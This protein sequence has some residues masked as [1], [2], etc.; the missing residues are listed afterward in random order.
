M[1]I[2]LRCAGESTAARALPPLNPPSLPSV[3]AAG[4]LEWAEGSLPRRLLDSL[5]GDLG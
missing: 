5:E 2:S 4:F 3:T 1:A